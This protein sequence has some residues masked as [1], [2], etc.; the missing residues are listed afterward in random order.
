MSERRDP[1]M[2]ISLL[3]AVPCVLYVV[4]YVADRLGIQGPES[5]W[6]RGLERPALL[7]GSLSPLILVGAI[8]LAA[9]SWPRA[10]RWTKVAATVAIVFA[11][12]AAWTFWGVLL[13]WT[14]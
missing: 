6:T 4:A 8:M 14:D 13:R 12:L 2:W 11:A 5:G 7:G 3:L 1:V 9:K 10:D